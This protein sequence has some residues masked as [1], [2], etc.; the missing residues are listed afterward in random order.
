ME[1][2]EVSTDRSNVRVRIKALAALLESREHGVNEA[3]Q[4]VGKAWMKG[5]SFESPSPACRRW[6]C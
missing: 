1:H 6:A 5:S 2:H 4:Q 3:D